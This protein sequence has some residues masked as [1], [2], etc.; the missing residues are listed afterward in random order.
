[1]T[2]CR[3][4]FMKSKM[5]CQIERPFQ[6][7]LPIHAM[8]N[9]LKIYLTEQNFTGHIL[10][11]CRFRKVYRMQHTLSLRDTKPRLVGHKPQ[12]LKTQNVGLKLE[13]VRDQQNLIRIVNKLFAMKL[14]IAQGHKPLWQKD[15]KPQSEASCRMETLNYSV[16][17]QILLYPL[18]LSI[19]DNMHAD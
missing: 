6:P 16:F 14:K 13:V 9:F 17:S 10:R 2:S 5:A 11:S 1:M 4:D 7:C 15:T 12:F 3:A 19:Y 18:R 8:L